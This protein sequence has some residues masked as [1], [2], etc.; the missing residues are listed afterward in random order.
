MEN[1]INLFL[2]PTKQIGTYPAHTFQPN[3]LIP[4]QKSQPNPQ[5]HYFSHFLDIN[6]NKKLEPHPSCMSS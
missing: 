4:Y 3:Y 1:A 6:Y 5:T 2:Y